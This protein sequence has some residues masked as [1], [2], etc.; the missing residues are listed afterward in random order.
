MDVEFLE[1]VAGEKVKNICMKAIND[2]AKR[3]KCVEL[4]KKVFCPR[5]VCGE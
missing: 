3:A 5:R 2:D 4:L 1:F